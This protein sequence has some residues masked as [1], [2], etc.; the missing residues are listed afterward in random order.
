[1]RDINLNLKIIRIVI[2]FEDGFPSRIHRYG[3]YFV[4]NR[5]PF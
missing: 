1:M 5:N 2:E 4:L 3:N